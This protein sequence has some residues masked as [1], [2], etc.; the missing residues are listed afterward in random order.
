[1]MVVVPVAVVTMGS[2]AMSRGE[3]ESPLSLSKYNNKNTGK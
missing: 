1:M 3:M 2:P